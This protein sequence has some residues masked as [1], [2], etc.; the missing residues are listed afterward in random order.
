MTAEPFQHGMEVESGMA[1]ES[2]L[3]IAVKLPPE[4]KRHLAREV[5]C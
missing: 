4:V 5:T 1:H 2:R 3:F